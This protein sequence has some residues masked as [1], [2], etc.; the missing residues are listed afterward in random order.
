MSDQDQSRA[1]LRS[2]KAGEAQGLEQLWRR[3]YEK[4][5]VHARRRIQQTGVSIDDE[6]IACS[7]FESVWKAAGNGRLASIES[8]EELWWWLISAAR[9][10]VI[11]HARRESAEKRGG[12]NPARQVDDLELFLSSEPGPEYFAVL[13]E[14]YQQAL[15]RLDD[16]RLREIAVMKLAGAS[17]MEISA[18]LKIAPAT[19]T[20]KLQVIYRIWT[21]WKPI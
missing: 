10:K 14:E 18:R 15:D 2:L 7:V 17:N 4:L 19:I 13:T 8:C 1:L 11:S 12:D 5:V 16:E 3:F 6:A 9:R 20:R 21:D